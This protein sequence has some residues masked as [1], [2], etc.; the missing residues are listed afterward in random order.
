M[1]QALVLTLLD[2]AGLVLWGGMACCAA[3][4]NRRAC[5]LAIGT[6]LGKPPHGTSV[7][8]WSQP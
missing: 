8:M 7:F 2:R 4:A 1:A 3:V 6:L 5:R